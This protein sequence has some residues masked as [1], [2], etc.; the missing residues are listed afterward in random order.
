[1]KVENIIVKLLCGILCCFFISSTAYAYS[2]AVASL[3]KMNGSVSVHLRSTGS[4]ISGR[5]GL[6]LRNGD[7]VKTGKRTKVSI[8]F[9]DGSEVRLFQNTR[10]LIEEAKES[11]G[12]KR[13][14]RYKFFMKLGSMWGKFIKNSQT[15]TQIKT[16]TATIGIKGT[17]L[18]ISERNSKSS[19][20]LSSGLISVKNDNEKIELKPG[21]MIS[22]IDKKGSIREKITRIPY[23]VLVRP[24]TKKITFR[25]KNRSTYFY[26]TLQLQNEKTKRNLYKRGKVHFSAN[27]DKIIFP[28]NVYL[29][30]RG[31]ARVRIQVKPLD[32][33]DYQRRSAEIVALMDGEEFHN[34]GAGLAVIPFDIPKGQKRIR[35]N[36]NSGSIIQQQ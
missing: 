3:G 33:K 20:S 31:Y 36:M 35:M 2:D 32:R 1:M 28:N 6:I 13:S 15:N 7:L 25:K 14:F 8:V 11:N 34:V 24:S 18:R 29:N 4:T 27:S 12:A 9:R 26:V 5:D 30:S 22:G 19:V 10:F 21:R 17:M 16:P 23:R